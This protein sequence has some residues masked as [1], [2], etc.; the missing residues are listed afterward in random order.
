MIKR[1]EDI[2]EQLSEERMDLVGNTF[3]RYFRSIDCQ[4]D[5]RMFKVFEKSEKQVF[6]ML[7]KLQAH[8]FMAVATAVEVATNAD[9][10]ELIITDGDDPETDEMST[11][12]NRGTM[13]A[14]ITLSKDS[15][16]YLKK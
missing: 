2:M 11:I 6:Q 7:D 12:V 9:E 13:Y 15:Q 1:V 5:W 4:I 16:K 3:D 10:A 8:Y 14:T